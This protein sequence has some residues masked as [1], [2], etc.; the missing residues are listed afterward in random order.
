M[1]IDMEALR[2][3]ERVDAPAARAAAPRLQA[4][5]DPGVA[6]AAKALSQ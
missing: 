4:D 3:L 6:R 5:P 2:A 1:D